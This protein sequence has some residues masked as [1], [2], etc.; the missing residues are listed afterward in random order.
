MLAAVVAANTNHGC[1]DLEEERGEREV[2][3]RKG[4]RGRS[5]AWQSVS[6][7]VETQQ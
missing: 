2:A 3:L 7:V 6:D 1:K 4:K 5:G